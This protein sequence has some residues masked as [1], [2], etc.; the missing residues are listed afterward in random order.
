MV[1]WTTFRSREKEIPGQARD[2]EE[3]S[4]EILLAQVREAL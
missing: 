3:L 2:D 4:D 1:V